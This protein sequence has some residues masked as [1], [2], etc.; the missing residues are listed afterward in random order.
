MEKRDTEKPMFKEEIFKSLNFPKTKTI[1]ARLIAIWLI[2]SS[3]IYGTIAI[4]ETNGE[5]EKQ[6]YVV[7]VILSSIT[8]FTFTL[9]YFLRIWTYNQKTIM[10]IQFS[11]DGI[12]LQVL[13]G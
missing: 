8:G 6:F 1:T 13:Q 3:L 4:L 7:F 9:E 5:L 11:N 2:F 10:K 12:T